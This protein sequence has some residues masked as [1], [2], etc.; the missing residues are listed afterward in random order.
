M[1]LF[2]EEAR[3][4]ETARRLQAPQDT[5][6]HE[7][8]AEDE[9]LLLWS[10]TTG[11]ERGWMIPGCQPDWMY[12][13]SW[14]P[15]YTYAVWRWVQSLHWAPLESGRKASDGAVHL[16]LLVNFVVCSGILPP[17]SLE[18]RRPRGPQHWP[19]EPRTIRKLTHSLVEITR[20]MARLSGIELWPARKRKVFVLRDLHK[21]GSQYGVA[22]RPRWPR[23][24]MRPLD[25]CDKFCTRAPVARLRHFV[26]NHVDP[27][28]CRAR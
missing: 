5:I 27:L 26:D 20:Q 11:C 24:L 14:P 23:P 2:C 15:W 22:L 3:Q 21:S 28:K 9:Q 8:V 1:E 16:E 4:K 12:A 13:C 7:E 19:E 18:D 10:R 17:A 6:L 25:C